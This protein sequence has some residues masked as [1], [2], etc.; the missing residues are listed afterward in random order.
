[1]SLATQTTIRDAVDVF[2]NFLESA[3]GR[4]SSADRKRPPRLLWH[5]IN[6]ATNQIRYERRVAKFREG[7]DASVNQVLP[8]VALKRVDIVQEDCPCAPARGCYWMKTKHPIPRLM[9]GLPQS[10]L[11]LDGTTTF[12]YMKW[13]DFEVVAKS[14]FSKVAKSPYYTIKRLQDECVYLYVYANSSITSSALLESVT[15]QGIFSDPEEV[16]RFPTCGKD[17]G[18]VCSMLDKPFYIEEELR[19]PIMSLARDMIFGLLPGAQ[20]ADIGTDS[21]N[22]SVNVPPPADA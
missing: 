10:V 21:I 19:L 12:D 6:S 7:L 17:I 22:T 4:M 13:S 14:R 5:F 11:T 20:A 16:A 9:E 1:M 15:V 18:N 3:D 2:S 8:C